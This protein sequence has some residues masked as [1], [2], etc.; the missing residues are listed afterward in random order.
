MV[1]LYELSSLFR[2]RRIASFLFGHV[3]AEQNVCVGLRVSVAKQ[4]SLCH[5]T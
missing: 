5:K 1:N 3:S 2:Q 4:M